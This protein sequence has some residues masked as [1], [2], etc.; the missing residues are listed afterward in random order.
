MPE[1]RS[2]TTNTINPTS[3]FPDTI[4]STTPNREKHPC[5]IRPQSPICT[6]RGSFNGSD[7]RSR[8]SLRWRNFDPVI[9]EALA[10]DVVC[11]NAIMQ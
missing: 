9:N 7:R 2:V 6:P 4:P 1:T 11:S 5:K 10:R 8:S 3:L